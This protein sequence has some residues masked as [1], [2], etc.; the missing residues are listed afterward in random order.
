MMHF[1]ACSLFPASHSAP[2]HWAFCSQLEMH[3][4]WYYKSGTG[5]N[6]GQSSFLIFVVCTDG[7]AVHCCNGVEPKFH[8][9]VLKGAYQ[10]KSTGTKILQQC[11]KMH[12]EV[13][14]G[15]SRVMR[16][17]AAHGVC[18]CQWIK[19][20]Y[21]FYILFFPCAYDFHGYVSCGT[22]GLKV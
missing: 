2:I 18:A 5:Y 13:F 8:H 15:C 3:Q 12:L 21:L 11:E 10:P 16:P 19:V 9:M 6:Q 7:A 1:C 14:P 17:E 20:M 22:T 4:T